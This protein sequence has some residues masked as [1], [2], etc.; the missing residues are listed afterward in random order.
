MGLCHYVI[1]LF[2]K[3]FKTIKRMPDELNAKLEGAVEQNQLSLVKNA[4]KEGADPNFSG[5]NSTPLNNAAFNGYDPIVK[6]LL[7]SGANVNL[8]DHKG[9][10]PIHLAVSKGHLKVCK[11]L[12]AAGAD[13]S[14]KTNDGGTAL[15][16]ASAY[17]FMSICKLLVEKACPINEKDKFDCNALH[18]AVGQVNKP[19]VKYLIEKG[20]D[21]ECTNINGHTPLLRA[22]SGLNESRVE[23]WSIETQNPSGQKR[24]Y[25]ISKGYFT[26]IDSGIEKPLAV[27]DQK[28]IASK[29]WGPNEHLKYLDL[30]DIAIML[31]NAGA[32]I[33]KLDKRNQNALFFSTRAGE[34]RLIKLFFDKGAN[35][36]VKDFNGA[37]LLHMAASSGRLDA[38]QTIL[39]MGFVKEINS[40][41]NFGWTPLHYLA[42]KGGSS[43][44]AQLLIGVG[45]DVGAKSTVERG[46]FPVGT[47]P[48]TVAMHFNDEEL[49]K[50]MKYK[51]QVINP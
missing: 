45:A 23:G 10:A 32:D 50:L 38:L 17:G 4:L 39:F 15:H 24:T 11:Q 25:K 35:H 6:L 28:L 29:E 9:F 19:L 16:I 8:Q 27:K 51:V 47:V 41:D 36:E 2:L 1:E 44:M 31:V 46:P 37:N 30:I 48:Y 43:E 7:S 18:V 3:L 5:T 13:L 21:V 33:N 20:A 49:A 34:M 12:I 22:L 40:E 26:F 14:L 42:D